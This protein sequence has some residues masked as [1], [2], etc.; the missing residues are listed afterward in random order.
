MVW[1]DRSEEPREA[2][3]RVG[4]YNRVSRGTRLP[5]CFSAPIE[6]FGW[7][8]DDGDD[9]VVFDF[10]V[11][12]WQCARRV[13]FG[14]NWTHAAGFRS[15]PFK[16]RSN[17]SADKKRRRNRRASVPP[18]RHL[19]RSNYARRILR[20]TRC[21]TTPRPVPSNSRLAGS[22]TWFWPHAPGGH[23]PREFSPANPVASELSIGKMCA[24][25]S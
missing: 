15:G 23:V 21:A 1:R 20:R 22:G 25:A 13:T 18:S 6:R 16:V 10:V 3:R 17:A 12:D 2:D 4:S 14:E 24:A 5:Q 8:R 7:L 11:E 9:D 19:T